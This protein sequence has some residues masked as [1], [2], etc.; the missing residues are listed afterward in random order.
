MPGRSGGA[1]RASLCIRT[2]RCRGNGSGARFGYP[3][4]RPGVDATSARLWLHPRGEF[5]VFGCAP[6]LASRLTY[7]VTA[8]ALRRRKVQA[9]SYTVQ[10]GRPE[11]DDRGLRPLVAL[12]E[13]VF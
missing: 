2:R 3:Q 11:I 13:D 4:G 6:I 9:H 10:D 5:L 12:V 7:G 1:L 8:L